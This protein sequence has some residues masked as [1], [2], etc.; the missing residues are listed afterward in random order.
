MYSS[1]GLAID[2]SFPNKTNI[3]TNLETLRLVKLIIDSV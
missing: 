1:S 3:N 2:V